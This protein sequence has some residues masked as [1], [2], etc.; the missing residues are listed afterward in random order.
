M[1]KGVEK[2]LASLQK[3]PYKNN[4]THWHSIPASPARCA[5]F[6]DWLHEKLRE[7]LAQRDIERLY[8][9]Q[10]EAVDL[11][12][13]GRNVVVG[14]P[15]AS[16]KTLCYNLPVLDA[17]LRDPSAR[18]LYLFPTKAL[19]MD[20][21]V[22]LAGLAELLDPGLV[23]NTYDGDTPADV[24]RKIR[25][26]GNVV[27]T[28][29]DM[30]HTG[31]LPHH[32]KWLTLFENLRYV[33]IDELHTY[34][35]VFG[36]HMANVI[37]RLKRI[38]G[39]YGSKPV[40][41]LSSATI[42][43]PKELAERLIEEEVELVDSSGAPTAQKH[44]ILYNPPLVLAT[45]GVR[46]SYV[47]HARRL[48]AKFIEAGVQTIVF[49]TAR[50]T[51]EVLVKYLKDAVETSP[52]RRGWI[53]GYRGGYLPRL[54][55][56]IEKGLRERTVRGV[57]STNAL[58]LGID[59]GALDCAVISGYPG[60]I[61][62]TWQQAGR[63]G[64]RSGIS[65]AVYV[66]RNLPHDQYVAFHP[67]FLFEQ[68]PE[69]A[70]IN[71]DN[72]L[73]LLEH[74]KCA[75][76]ELPFGGDEAF[77]GENPAELLDYLVEGGLVHRTGEPSA[78]SYAS[79]K[80]W[81][82]MAD[83]YPAEAV[84]LRSMTRDNFVI[85][86]LSGRPAGGDM[87][88]GGEPFEERLAR[89]G[90]NRP[91]VIGEVDYSGA[92]YHIFP[93]AT[94]VHD[95]ISYQVEELDFPNRKA[96]VRRADSDYYTDAEDRTSVR[97][98]DVFDEG[99]PVAARPFHGEV[100]V[101]TKVV[102]FKKIRYYTQE[103]VGY[104][105]VNL[106]ER[107]MS[108]TAYWAR[109]S[110]KM[111]DGLPFNRH[112]LVAGLEGVRYA[113]HSLAAFIVMCELRDLGSAIGVARGDDFSETGT[114]AELYADEGTEL[115]P[116]LEPLI[117][118]YDNYPGGIGFSEKLFALHRD[119]WAGVLA[120]IQDCPCTHGCPSCIGPSLEMRGPKGTII[121]VPRRKEAA[122]VILHQSL[123]PRD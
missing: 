112:E 2:V 95:G 34:R 1:K 78:A 38:A 49:A 65:V 5:D 72:L 54:R 28:N 84:S 108:T 82:W 4:I 51:T 96:Y 113:L 91:R 30:L 100:H 59:I 39:H 89:A 20:Q 11:V 76:F 86:E 109:L 46:E 40:F 81:Y 17:M 52:D 122:R 57:V 99:K 10:R 9:H 48:A 3:A 41:I 92:F 22:E 80:K 36:S 103:N 19:S 6:P 26:G 21:L 42:A 12:H 115:A 35:G 47:M 32:T 15:T 85:V 107:Q 98:L 61:A 88:P 44:F 117:F 16:G 43:N 55:R 50:I 94:Y 77:G 13:A 64:R 7:A 83:S 27:I 24:R 63:A 121:P 29:P 8:T 68:S 111:L 101:S 31:I 66:A 104:G 114:L 53:R 67:E 37:R 90:D 62:S 33:V 45:T 87:E 97:I 79:G 123:A 70:R 106:P 14:T 73:I 119:L 71:P 69:H 105:E 23:A 60:S 58:E 25:R 93:Q 18:A 110:G 74:V 75:C 56:E 102:G 118:I 116:G 120:R